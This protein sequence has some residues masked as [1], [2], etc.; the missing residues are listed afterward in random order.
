MVFICKYVSVLEE[1]GLRALFSAGYEHK[2]TPSILREH[3]GGIKN[4]IGRGKGRTLARATPRQQTATVRWRSPETAQ[5]L[6]KAR[7]EST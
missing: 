5:L 3:G 4:A 1:L 7:M 2:T 6:M